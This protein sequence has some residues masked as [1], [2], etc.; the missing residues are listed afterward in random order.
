MDVASKIRDIERALEDLNAQKQREIFRIDKEIKDME[1]KLEELKAQTQTETVV[2]FD[3]FVTKQLNV[4]CAYINAYI[5]NPEY[6]LPYTYSAI[7]FMYIIRELQVYRTTTKEMVQRNIR[8]IAEFMCQRICFNG[9]NNTRII[10]YKS[11]DNGIFEILLNLQSGAKKLRIF[12]TLT[13][14]TAF[15]NEYNICIDLLPG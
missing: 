2:N 10:S 8:A 6:G 13:Q 12:S 11:T 4:L 15:H 3:G 5:T 14:D 9:D 1:K 7:E